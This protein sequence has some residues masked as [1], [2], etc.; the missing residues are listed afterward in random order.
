M[1]HL[2]LINIYLDGFRACHYDKLSKLECPYSIDS[3]EAHHWHK[4]YDYAE[5]L[6]KILASTLKKSTVV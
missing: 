1:T 2:K 4:G 5:N 6:N 3:P